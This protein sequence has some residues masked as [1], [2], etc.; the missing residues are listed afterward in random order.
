MVED[1]RGLEDEDAGSGA[2]FRPLAFIPGTN[3]PDTLNGTPGA[4][5]IVGRAGNDTITGR[6]GNDTLNGGNGRDN[7]SG[8][9][10]D[11]RILGGAGN[12]TLTGDAGNDNIKAGNGN[13]WVRGGVGN[14]RILGGSG[15]DILNGFDGDD[16][17]HGG[18]GN[19]RLIGGRGDDTLDGRLGFDRMTGGPGADTFLLA[20]RDGTTDLIRDFD[21]TIDRLDVSNIV[22]FEAGDN[23]NDFVRFRQVDNG[24]EVRISPNGGAPFVTVAGLEGVNITSLSAA[25][26]GLPTGGGGTVDEA[27]VVS[28][29]VGGAVGNGISFLPSLSTDG[30]LITFS[31]SSTNLTAADGNGSIFDIYQK[32]IATGEVTRITERNVP[33]AGLQGGD[34]DSFDSSIAGDGSLVAFDSLANN[35]GG[36]D[37]APRDVYVK[38]G[39]QIEL[40]SI[41]NNQFAIAPSVSGDG[42][43]VAFQA[44]ATGRAESGNPAPLD[45]IFPRIYVRDLDT[46]ELT[47]VS[48]A[49]NAPNSFA[50]ESSFDPDISTDGNFVAFESEATNLVDGD[51][52]GFRDVFVKNLSNGNVT[53]VSTDSEGDQGFGGSSDASISGDGRFVAFQTNAQLAEADFTGG[54]SDIYVKDLQDG[55]TQLVTINADG[56]LADG[57]SFT[58]SISDDGRFVAFRSAATNLVEGDGNGQADIFVADLNEPGS[59]LRF[60]IGSDTSGALS[61]LVQP[62]LS[63]DGSL[64]AFLTDV[65]VNGAGGLDSAQVTVA[66]VEFDSAPAALG[67]ADVLS[68]GGDLA[69][70]LA[71]AGAVDTGTSQSLE[72]LITPADVI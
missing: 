65:E 49:S 38:D 61:D 25:Q 7:I 41:A 1:K 34:D 16:F 44:T 52:G 50:N 68:D 10:G 3:G 30:G 22:N 53:L 63:G 59:F 69:P 64:V 17:L 9:Q 71:A 21:Q 39:N 46:G 51:A 47:E 28:A 60:Q 36:T 15:S 70:A 45:T 62:E 35:F 5:R 55:S 57:E 33:G 18:A 42:G 8:Q 13:D 31:S 2:V 32:N 40:V 11:D 56:I 37:S 14:D 58:P 12:D 67:V 29:N 20:T 23:V 4:D 27:T 43:L 6:A 19:D 54:S 24:T 26:L 72:S 66:P 48:T